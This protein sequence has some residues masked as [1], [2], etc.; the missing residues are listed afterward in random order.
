MLDFL[1]INKATVVKYPN[2]I[3]KEKTKEVEFPLSEA[4]KNLIK[5]IKTYL[6]ESNDYDLAEKKNLEPAV[7]IAAPQI[8]ISLRLC[9]LYID[10]DDNTDIFKRI[11]INPKIVSASSQ[12]SYLKG[13]EGC[14]S[15]SPKVEGLVFRHAKIKVKYFNETG[16]E[17]TEEFTDFSAIAVQH[18]IDHLNGVLYI[19][20]INYNDPFKILKNAVEI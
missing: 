5:K 14:L 8:G 6:Y 19:D 11:M 4:N 12:M 10:T 9:G 3:L 17:I 20:H 7:G 1:P 2:P 13:G 18:E 15:I 16:S